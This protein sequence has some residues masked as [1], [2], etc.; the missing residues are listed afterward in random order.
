MINPS[1]YREDT[2]IKKFLGGKVRHYPIRESAVVLSSYP[3]TVQYGDTMYTI[4]K[5]IFG[6][7][8]EYLWTIIA[9]I[10]YIRE[11]DDL[12]PG[13]VI[14]LPIVILDDSK[15]TKIAYDKNKT[16]TTPI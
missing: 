4:A 13:E 1:F 3:Y 12:Q 6:A 10:N 11:P 8:F 7:D 9:D 16:T 15:Y 2:L 14:K 5:K